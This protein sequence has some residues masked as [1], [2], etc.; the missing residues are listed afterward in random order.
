MN[1]KYKVVI[2]DHRF[3][4]VDI[5]REVLSKIGAELVV[6]QAQTEEEII[7]IAKDAHG[8]LNARSKITEKVINAL[9]CC[10][11]MVR[12][13]VG[14]DTIDIAAATRKGIMVSNVLDYCVDEVSDHALALVLALTRKVV[15]SARRVRAGEWSVANLKPLKRLSGQTLGVVGYG[16]IGRELARKASP[17]GFNV[18]VYDPYVDEKAVAKTGFKLA[19][20]EE[21]IKGSDVIS[22]HSPLTPETKGMIGKQQLDMMKPN[23]Y[24]VNVSRGSLI[25]EGAL[26]DALNAGRIAGAGLDV[27]IDEPAKPDNPLLKMEQV[28]VTSHTAFYSDEAIQEL[29]KK[30]AE[31]VAAALTGQIPDPLVNP[32]VLKS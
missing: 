4:N 19:S 13:G 6:G 7:A 29:Q 28:I 24:I 2:T 12:Y 16:R 32:E 17:I 10:K 18:L 3:P 22:L 23:A 15:F 26:I 20:F 27:M 9:T 14:V 30:A 21:L 1:S 25:D 5:Q 8:I 11:I 31:K